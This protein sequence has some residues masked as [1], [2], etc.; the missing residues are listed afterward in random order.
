MKKM[1]SKRSKQKVNFIPQMQ[2]VCFDFMP[3]FYGDVTF[4]VC[5]LLSCARVHRLSGFQFYAFFL[6]ESPGLCIVSTGEFAS[7]PM[8]ALMTSSH[9]ASQNV[10]H[11]WT[12]G[13]IHACKTRI[14]HFSLH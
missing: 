11:A 13:A 8:V 10:L 3:S 2:A 1:T 4:F 12:D 7:L 14:G 6:R 9:L 5:V